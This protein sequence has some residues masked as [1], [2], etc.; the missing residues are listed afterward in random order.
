LTLNRETQW[1]AAWLI[2]GSI[3]VSVEKGKERIF[4]FEKRSK[5]LLSA[6]RGGCSHSGRCVR[7]GH[8][9]WPDVKLRHG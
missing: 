6:L 5:K 7:H 8:Q 2:L 1:A 4:F 3:K 9:G